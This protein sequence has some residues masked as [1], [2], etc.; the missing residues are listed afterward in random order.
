MRRI[1]MSETRSFT[2][3]NEYIKNHPDA[4]RQALEALRECILE[5]APGATGM[6]NYNIRAFALVGGGK[7]EEQIMMAGYKNHVGLYP[8]PTVIEHFS[9][10]LKPFKQGKGS[11]QFPVNKPI[12]KVLV[13]RM[14]KYRMKLLKERII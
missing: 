5:A 2:S 13:V 8:H 11:V 4:T 12:P 10:E 1:D 3:I 6:F 7:Q 9:E 14:I